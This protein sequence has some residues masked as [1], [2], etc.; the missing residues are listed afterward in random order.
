METR[1]SGRSDWSGMNAW[2]ALLR[3]PEQ[4]IPSTQAGA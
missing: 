3:V 4:T 1:V 2:Q